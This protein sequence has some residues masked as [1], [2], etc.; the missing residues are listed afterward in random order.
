MFVFSFKK[1]LVFF[2]WT[3]NMENYKILYIEDDPIEYEMVKAFL[4]SKS[5]VQSITQVKT[6]IDF[7]TEIKSN[8]YDI[9]LTD[10]ILK[11]FHGLEALHLLKT[12]KVNIPVIFI[13]GILPDEIAVEVIKKGAADYILLQNIYRLVPSIH[14]VVERKRMQDE[15]NFALTRLRESEE[16]YRILAETSPYGII[17]HNNFKLK[18]YNKQALLIF[19]AFEDRGFHE[20]NILEFI[21]KEYQDKIQMRL[22]ELNKGEDNQDF[23]EEVFLNKAGDLIQVEV[24]SAGI[25]Y[26]GE[27]SSQVIFRDISERK[28]MEAELVKAKEKAE[29]SDKLKTAFLEN[30]SHEIRTPL[31][32]IIGFSTLLKYKNLETEERI[33]YLDIIEQSGKHLLKIINDLIEISRIESGHIEIRKEQVNLNN[34]LDDLLVFFI[35]SAKLKELPVNILLYKP[36]QNEVSFV[37]TDYS[38]LKQVFINLLNNALKFTRKGEIKFGYEILDENMIKFYVSDSGIGIPDNSKDFIFER[39]RQVDDTSTREFGGAGLGLTISKGIVEIMGGKIWF[40][41]VYGEGTNFY[42]TLPLS[43]NSASLT[44]ANKKAET[45]FDTNW[46]GKHL[47]IAEDEQSNYLLIK[48]LLKNTGISVDRA[49]NGLEVL[50]R[51]EKDPQYYDLIL[52]DIKMPEMD[53]LQAIKEIRKRKIFIPVIAQ[54]AYAMTDDRQKCINAGFDEYITKPIKSSELFHKINTMVLKRNR[55][56][57]NHE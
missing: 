18:Y 52:M 50:A 37:N 12:E 32:G 11:F 23:Y 21:H 35:N 53:G 34:I 3:I 29:E 10:F 30:M 49:E 51:L 41:S 43:L 31:N 14:S 44:E 57:L 7:L 2:A 1:C 6:K 48:H 9:I 55:M 42:F 39:F 33:K 19:N 22:R 4:E 54:T 24:A 28:R 46:K 25:N 15:K 26:Y 17:V 13:T 16:N 56:D 27:P 20:R 45:Q 38:R 40:D 36:A 47:L 5:M 8:N